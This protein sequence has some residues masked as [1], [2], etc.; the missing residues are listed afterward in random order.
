MFLVRL[1]KILL[2]I[3]Y[4]GGWIFLYLGFEI[5]KKMNGKI[6]EILLIFIYYLVI[7][8]FIIVKNG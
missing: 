3:L 6:S 8:R 5:K 2:L 1:C 7:I 4:F